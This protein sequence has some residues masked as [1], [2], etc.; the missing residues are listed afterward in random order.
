MR[1][2]TGIRPRRRGYTVSVRVNGRLI[3]KQFPA[4]TSF[5]AMKAWRDQQRAQVN[6]SVGGSFAAD[7]ETYLEKPE[8]AAR[9]Y[10]S[11]ERAILRLWV[12]ELGADRPRRSITRD[13]IE[14]VLQRWLKRYKEPTVYHRRSTLLGLFTTLDGAG[15]ANPVKDT[16]C[17]KAWVPADHSVPFA[18]LSAIVDAMTPWR[19]PRKGIRQPAIAQLVARVMIAV[20]LRPVDLQRVRRH[21]L[22][23]QAETLRWPASKKGKGVPA[24]PYQLNPEALA[25][26]RAFDAANA[27]GAFKP[28]AVSHSFKRAARRVCGAD[29]SIHLYVLRHSVGADLYRVRGDLATVGR[30]LGHAPGSRATAQYA[31]GANADVDRAAMMALSAARTAALSAAPVQPSAEKSAGKSAASG[32]AVRLRGLQRVS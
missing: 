5:D 21:D 2:Q 19:Y 10:V 32:K 7:V 28:E 13:E 27:Y 9:K 3:T 24:R 20:G 25:A 8:V 26:F 30:A 15:A 1:K 22:D 18:T 17:P 16:T 11:Q 6:G 31:Q 4:G 14:A 12:H 23:W 29:T